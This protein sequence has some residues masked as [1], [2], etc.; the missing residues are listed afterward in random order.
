MNLLI[1]SLWRSI[2]ELDE[3]IRTN[4]RYLRHLE[5][6]TDK[7]EQFS[8][9]I[10]NVSASSLPFGHERIGRIPVPD[11]NH[12]IARQAFEARFLGQL[13]N[14][15]L[16]SENERQTLLYAIQ[17]TGANAASAAS[18][19]DW[20]R[21]HEECVGQDTK[22][23]R[24]EISCKIEFIHG[25]SDSASRAWTPVEDDQLSFLVTENNGTNWI[26]IG[27]IMGRSASECYSRCYTNLHPV[28][29]PA[30]FAPEDDLKLKNAIETF[31]DGSWAHVAMELGTG[32]TDI[33]C[34]N[35]WNKTLK[36]GITSGRWNEVLDKKL[37]AAVAIYGE[38]KWS[39]IAKHVPGKTDRKCRERYSE[40]FVEGLK[41]A[42]DWTPSED[43]MLKK[44]ARRH[45]VGNWSKIK[46]ELNGRT[47]Q[48]C[49]LRFKRI[50][51]PDDL[52]E[53]YSE[54]LDRH[55]KDKLARTR[56]TPPSTPD[57]ERK[58][59]PVGRPRKMDH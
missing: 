16:W 20:E 46:D 33:Q 18:T 4:D 40:N 57:L 12:T 34:M 8:N 14:K 38:G 32:H 29:V 58:K 9:K 47:D 21:V 45:G 24:S 30:D 44:A 50:D 26:E 3:C 51:L 48:M 5:R 39:S 17:S 22:F 42:G 2:E 15:Q 37:V 23:T 27:E 49:R 31:G 43:E 35:R 55:R 7:A 36:P 54:R 19:I 11:N 41:P 10:R 1:E 25:L 56:S 13:K 6:Y 52:N 28:I 59:R 53:A